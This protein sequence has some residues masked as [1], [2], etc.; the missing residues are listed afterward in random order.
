MRI[1]RAEHFGGVA[2]KSTRWWGF[3]VGV[4]ARV[5]QVPNRGLPLVP[6]SDGTLQ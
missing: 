3:P 2:E 4:V 6:W 5:M 1:E